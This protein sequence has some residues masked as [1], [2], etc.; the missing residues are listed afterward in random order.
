MELGFSNRAY[1]PQN[2][3]MESVPQQLQREQPPAHARP[4]FLVHPPSVLEIQ[5]AVWPRRS[6]PVPCQVPGVSASRGAGYLLQGGWAGGTGARVQHRTP[7]GVS[8]L[9]PT[10]CPG[11]S[12]YVLLVVAPRRNTG[13][14]RQ[15]RRGRLRSTKGG[16]AGPGRC[17]SCWWWWLSLSGCRLIR[18]LPTVRRSVLSPHTL[19]C[20]LQ[21]GFLKC[22]HLPALCRLPGTW[23]TVSR[24]KETDLKTLVRQHGWRAASSGVMHPTVLPL[25][26]RTRAW[27][28][29]GHMFYPCL[30]AASWGML[31]TH[32]LKRFRLCMAVFL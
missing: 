2:H 13:G 6:P 20:R 27:T 24:G 26:S 12:I 21:T 7:S 10:A 23:I 28:F 1:F 14:G 17:L 4:L 30:H 11:S 3:C 15:R 25:R 22:Q 31:G 9:R 32:H 19:L 18:H 8:S 29:S 5:D 16:W